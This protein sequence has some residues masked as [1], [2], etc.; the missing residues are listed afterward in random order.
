MSGRRFREAIQ[1]EF[2]MNGRQNM[3]VV[4]A[5][6]CN[7][8]TH[9]ITT[10]E[11]Y[12]VQRYE[13][14]STIYGPH[15]L[16][17][18]IQL[19]SGLARAIATDTVANLSQGPDPPFFDGLMT[20]LTPN[21]PDKAPGSMAFGDV[22]QPPK[23][24]YHGGEVAEVMFVGANPKYSAENV[25][26]HNFLTVE[27]YEDSSAM[28]QVVLNDASWDTRFYWH[29][30]S[31]GLSNVTIEWH[32]AGTTPP[33]LYR[34]HYFGH[35]RKQSFLQPAKILAFDGASDPFQVVAP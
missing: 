11:E 21:T 2:E 10:Y 35:N 19:F 5:G 28:W 3:S 18:Y 17:A 14:A 13:A 23:T 12:Q 30:G 7:V 6:L 31:S 29:K 26:D 32:I 24:E 20:P 16:S 9:Y 8:Y 4:I 15:T 33:G 22:L 34:I 1:K 25:T 27:K